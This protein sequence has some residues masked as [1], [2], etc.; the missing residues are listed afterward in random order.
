MLIGRR[1]S[2]V[3]LV[4][5]W[6]DSQ[7]QGSGRG[8]SGLEQKRIRLAFVFIGS[9]LLGRTVG[10]HPERTNPTFPY[11]LCDVRLQG[12]DQKHTLRCLNRGTVDQGPSPLWSMSRKSQKVCR[13]LHLTSVMWF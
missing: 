2:G 1:Y 7:V 4:S 13:R 8:Y 10:I 5:P 11:A 6:E 12:R 3:V 9:W